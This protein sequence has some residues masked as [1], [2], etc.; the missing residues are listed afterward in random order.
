ME[1]LDAAKDAE[2]LSQL[3]DHETMSSFLERNF[4]A[5]I[6]DHDPMVEA[7]GRLWK[8][9]TRTAYLDLDPSKTYQKIN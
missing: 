6:H 3:C 1:V 8:V 5:H 9:Q 2:D 4:G 7:Y